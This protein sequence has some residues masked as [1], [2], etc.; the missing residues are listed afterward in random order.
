MQRHGSE[1]RRTRLRRRR[2][3]R[4]LTAFGLVGVG[5][6]AVSAFT[7][8]PSVVPFA[9]AEQQSASDG[10][11]PTP[12]LGPAPT[13]TPQVTNRSSNAGAVASSQAA[14]SAS[15]STTP[16]PGS[17][18]SGP[19]VS[20]DGT[21]NA[22][23]YR[24]IAGA[25][26]T[27]AG[28]AYRFGQ[29]AS[30]SSSADVPTAYQPPD[31]VVDNHGTRPNQTYQVG[32]PQNPA[33]DDYSSNQGQ[34]GYLSN[35]G[36]TFGADTIETLAMGENTFSEKPRLSWTFNGGGHPAVDLVGDG[37]TAKCL[38]RLKEKP[39]RFVAQARAYAHGENTAN[40]L[41]VFDNGVIAAAG[42]NTA[43]GSVC[44]QLPN[45]LHPTAISITNG[46]EF[47]LVTVWNTASLRSELAVIAL[48]GSQPAGAFWN[49]EWT[50]LY[51][52]LQNYGMPTFAK[53]LGTVVLPMATPTGVSAV[54]DYSFGKWLTDTGGSNVLPG[55]FSLADEGNRQTFISGANREKYATGGYAVVFSREEHKVAFVDLQPLF[56]SI[57]GAYFRDR[58][59]FDNAVK[60]VGTA[61]GQWPQAFISSAPAQIPRVVKTITTAQAPT[62]VAAM[63][64]GA[65]T[66]RAYVA[67]AEGTL[68]VFEVG[69][70]ASEAAADPAA[71][72]EK[73]TIPVGKNPTSIT[74]TKDRPEHTEGL[75]SQ[76]IVTARGSRAV[77]WVKLSGDSGSIVRTL[78]DS[79]LV[80]PIAAEDNNTHG[81]ESYVV[82]I[83][84]FGAGKLLN[85][86]HGPVVFHTNGGSTF[87]VGGSRGD[88]F[89]YGGSYDPK[90]KPFSISLTNVT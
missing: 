60:N 56:T 48:G 84:D 31:K 69:G 11:L 4:R 16:A 30:S 18:S 28:I 79:R 23:E 74:Y 70:L 33:R 55:R 53:L 73:G 27:E 44:L 17:P 58:A 71:I 10:S 59:T 68:H 36:S 32:G 61:A 7:V 62:A 2:A 87:G 86:R 21:V 8:L 76:L 41:L 81:T 67:T 49:N 34:V 77:Q 6:L 66:P 13:W 5:V 24:R 82:S 25:M 89:E 63:L 1:L 54:S 45:D 43:P 72:Q 37:A 3:R 12:S 22:A 35:G 15:A 39:G 14:A 29:A 19:I 64:S 47:A 90:G 9:L 80:D 46:N 85:Y 26:G 52:G 75:D 88:A 65:A 51:P 78:R 83:A 42:T 20:A 40:S 50:Q 57:T 38:A